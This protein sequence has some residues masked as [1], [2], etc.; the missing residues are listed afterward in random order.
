MKNRISTRNFNDKAKAY[1]D[2]KAESEK[3]DSTIKGF[4]EAFLRFLKLHGVR[5]DDAPKS[6]KYESDLYEALSYIGQKTEI[7]SDAVQSFSI[8]LAEVGLG[9]LFPQI[10][11][12]KTSYSL[13]P[14][15]A[16]TVKAL[17]AK[18]RRA[19][20]RTQITKPKTPSL[21]VELKKQ[22][23]SKKELERREAVCNA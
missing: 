3:I 17:R 21:K 7:N 22:P 2:L 14:T 9:H 20:S 6:K 5:P 8:A 4:K 1:L 16:E 13:A 11:E 23:P 10:F 12:A 18:H 19:Y 15:A